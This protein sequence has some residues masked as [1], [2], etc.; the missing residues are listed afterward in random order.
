MKDVA[1]NLNSNT[2]I[3][4]TES[5]TEHIVNDTMIS[6]GFA[7]SVLSLDKYHTTFQE[8]KIFATKP[9][10]INI[11]EGNIEISPLWINDALKVTGKYNLEKKKGELHAYADSLNVSHKKTSLK[12]RVDK[13]YISKRFFHYSWWKH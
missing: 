11:K 2:L 6:L 12:S 4:K 3:Y 5:K 9:S 7:N 10:V 13:T 8:Q 1:L